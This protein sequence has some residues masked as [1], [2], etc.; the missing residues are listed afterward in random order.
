MTDQTN[1]RLATAMTLLFSLAP[2]GCMNPGPNN[3]PLDYRVARS[4]E[5]VVR[6][7]EVA[8][9]VLGSEIGENDVREALSGT[10]SSHPEL[11]VQY[12]A[13]QKTLSIVD[14]GADLVENSHFDRSVVDSLS[15]RVLA[16]LDER[17]VV[18]MA[19]A[20][21]VSVSFDASGKLGAIHIT[22]F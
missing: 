7:G 9:V 22:G 13:H 17:G 20:T 21:S 1:T 3:E 14:L 8:E 19:D 6:T 10:M 18:D 16:A 4:D 5:L 12:D 11:L 15:Q 2:Q